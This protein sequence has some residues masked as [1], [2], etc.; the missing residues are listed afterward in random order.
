MRKI[1]TSAAPAAIGP[2]SQAIET[3]G[4]LFVSG[5]IPIV[6]DLDNRMPEDICAQ[7]MVVMRNIEAILKE[8]GLGFENVV[9]TTIFLTDLKS[10]AAVNEAYGS[11]FE[12]DPPAR[13]TVE[14]S[15]LPKG[16]KVEIE[17]IAAFDK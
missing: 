15:S 2:Y 10:F 8:A 4:F 6:P 17:T 1:E 9:K 16:A 13:S 14:V 7:T 5:Q 11:F 12:G 3:N